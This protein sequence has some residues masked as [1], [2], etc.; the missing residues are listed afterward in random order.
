MERSFAESCERSGF[1]VV[2]YSIQSDHGH[3]I[4]EAAH[5]EALGRGMKSL[6]AR[7][8][9]AVNRAFRRQ[10]PVLAERYHLRVLRSPRQVRNAL[11]YVLLNARR[12]LVKR[13]GRAA[14]RGVRLDPASS[15]GWFDGWRGTP[16]TPGG[17]R[18]GPTAPPVAPAHTWLLR[19]GWRRHGMI[20]P[21]EVPG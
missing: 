7:F 5:R 20:D 13:R 16:G 18:D 3:F 17:S 11:A 21:A 19:L 6:A 12:H 15:A 9:R 8:A 4:V 1:R 14:V 10:G 2:H